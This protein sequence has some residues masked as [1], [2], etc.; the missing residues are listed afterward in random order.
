MEYDEMYY[1]IYGEVG[2]IVNVCAQQN[3]LETPEIAKKFSMQKI[4]GE[5]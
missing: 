3:D 2:T 5:N 1:T 4:Q